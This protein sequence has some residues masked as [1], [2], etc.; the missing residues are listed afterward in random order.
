MP[1]AERR[2]RK[3][4]RQPTGVVGHRSEDASNGQNRQAACVDSRFALCEGDRA[5]P[6]YRQT[7]RKGILSLWN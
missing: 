6:I 7:R 2:F 4:I 3:P 5:W 1:R